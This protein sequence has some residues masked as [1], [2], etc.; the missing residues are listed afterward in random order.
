MVDATT[1]TG[2][3][4]TNFDGPRLRAV[5]LGLAL[6]TLLLYLPVRHH[7]FIRF[8]DV[9]YLSGN[10][11]VQGG[12]SWRGV[13][14]AFTTWHA[15]N[16][17]PLTWI[18]HM[19]DWQLFGPEAG[20]HHLMNVLLHGLNT[21]LVCVLWFRLTGRLWPAAMV[22]ALFAWHPLHVESVAWASE[23]KDVLSTM[24]FLLTL[25]AYARH[26]RNQPA[27]A[28]L[29]A[30]SLLTTRT[31]WA[32]IGLFALGLLAKPMLVTLPFVL[33]LLDYWPLNRLPDRREVLGGLLP[34]VA[35]KLPLF[36]LAAVSCLI[37]FLAQ[38]TEA[39]VS[40]DAIPLSLRLGNA[41]QAYGDYLIK[42]IWPVDLAVFYPFPV[43]V[44]TGRIFLTASFLLGTSV[45]V[46]WAG[47][48]RR[49]LG[50]GWCWYLGTLVPVI[51]LVQVGNQAMADRYTYIPLLGIFVIIAY[52]GR[53]WLAALQINRIGTGFLACLPL[54][55]C[56]YA[57]H[58]QIRHWQDSETLFR[59]TIAVTKDNAVA[60][61]VLGFALAGQGLKEEAVQEFQTALR[62]RPDMADVHND[63]AVVL[64]A[65]RR[66]DEATKHY[67]EAVRLSPRNPLFIA[68]LAQHVAQMGHFDEALAGFRAVLQIEP[69]NP[70]LYFLMGK[71]QR[72]CGQS[73][74]AIQ[75]FRAGLQLAPDDLENAAALCRTLAADPAPEVRNGAEAVKLGERI[76][77]LLQGEQPQV[78]DV[79]AMAY[80][81]TGRYDLACATVAKALSLATNAGSSAVKIAM[82]ERLKLY[83]AN[84]PYRE[85]W[86]NTR[87]I[88]LKD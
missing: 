68:N 16:W 59:H 20:A 87:P 21:V 40:L 15:S 88:L 52:G 30:T 47:K 62:I 55:G 53:E 57:T 44:A 61:A 49:Y 58:R 32:V 17:H 28:G 84:Q 27:T 35:E 64:Q 69:T 82:Q 36:V 18:S 54:V 12:L 76:N 22:A 13:V 45:A 29:R 14:W 39:V 70:H 10:P 31:G 74:S 48:S 11:A 75:S 80:A 26:V 5:C 23:R 50:L 25:M 38:R 4:T 79:L 67:R 41:L 77:T 83:E 78:L 65:L 63:L 66:P 73:E 37:T 24:F 71:A 2:K 8:D 7:D 81:E 33:L 60:H 43:T 46:A 9:E 6:I 3:A 42:M 19:L 34:L 72:S 56:L 85:N 1:V 51:G 86:T